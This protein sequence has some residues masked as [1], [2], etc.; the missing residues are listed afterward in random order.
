MKDLFNDP[1]VKKALRDREDR[2]NENR[3]WLDEDCTRATEESTASEWNKH[4]VCDE[5]WRNRITRDLTRL[6]GE[7]WNGSS[8]SLRAQGRWTSAITSVMEEGVA[9]KVEE[10]VVTSVKREV[11]PSPK[12]W[13]CGHGTGR[14]KNPH[15]H[16]VAK[17][18]KAADDGVLNNTCSIFHGE[19]QL[20]NPYGLNTHRQWLRFLKNAVI[21]DIIFLHCSKKGGLLYWG[22]YI[23]V[24]SI[25]YKCPVSNKSEIQSLIKVVKWTPLPDIKKGVGSNCTLYEVTEDSK[26]YENYMIFT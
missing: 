4:S 25:P 23:G 18:L 26:N 7:L 17:H 22:E 21:G 10:E 14:G 13:H 24:E 2:Y 11:L 9:G 16:F 19:W 12:I 15:P 3:R 1:Q 5:E 8:R 20:E 6:D